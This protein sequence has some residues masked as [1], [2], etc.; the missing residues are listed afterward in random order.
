M[1][2]ISN[3]KAKFTRPLAGGFDEYSPSIS[4]KIS[5]SNWFDQFWIT[6][7][8]LFAGNIVIAK[9]SFAI[10]FRRRYLGDNRWPANGGKEKCNRDHA[11]RHR[12]A[13][14]LPAL[15][16]RRRRSIRASRR[17]QRGLPRRP[18]PRQSAVPYSSRPPAVS[19]DAGTKLLITQET[20]IYFSR[21]KSFL[22]CHM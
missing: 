20:E 16:S 7:S 1:N 12:L 14:S 4:I 17:R 5:G 2:D 18:P 10:I 19:L 21:K 22:W 9:L 8:N 15:A 3:V 13:T 11:L 6:I